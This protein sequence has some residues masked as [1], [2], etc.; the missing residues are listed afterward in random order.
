MTLVEQ[1]VGREL[2]AGGTVHVDP[3]VR[4]VGVVPG[5]P[6]RDERCALAGQPRGLGVA[7]I[8][9]GHDERVDGRGP[10]QVVVRPDRVLGAAGEQQHVV[11]GLTGGLHER[12]HEAVHR[13]VGGAFLGR[14]ELQP[15]QVAGAGAE[16]A[17]STVG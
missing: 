14:V 1:V 15:D 8:G 6:E 2:G 7:Q 17:R 3:R 4:G 5:T 11:A 12:V 10:Q 16:V 9:V 13:R